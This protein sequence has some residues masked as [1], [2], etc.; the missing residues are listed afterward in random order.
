VDLFFGRWLLAPVRLAPQQRELRIA[1][2]A[3]AVATPPASAPSNE[4][5]DHQQRE[6]PPATV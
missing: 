2:A 1:R 5:H 3:L 4:Q 6:E